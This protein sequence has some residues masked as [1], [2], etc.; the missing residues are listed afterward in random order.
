MLQEGHYIIAISNMI[1]H[2]DFFV[3]TAYSLSRSETITILLLEQ[4]PHGRP[5]LAG[6]GI[7]MKMQTMMSYVI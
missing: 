7:M 1:V 2:P 4:S 5:E 3:T 6:R